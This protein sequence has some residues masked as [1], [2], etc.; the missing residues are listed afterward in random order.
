MSEAKKER[1]TKDVLQEYNNL[2]FRAGNLQYE[3]TCKE[4][5]L[6][7]INNAMKELNFEYAKLKK[8]EDEVAAAVAAAKAEAEKKEAPKLEVV[9]PATTEASNG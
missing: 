9:P 5:D 1:T 6:A 3:I 2:A 4:A 7:G 8:T